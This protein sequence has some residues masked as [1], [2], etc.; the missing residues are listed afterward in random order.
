MDPISFAALVGTAVGLA[1]GVVPFAVGIKNDRFILG[2][3]SFAFCGAVEAAFGLLG[4]IPTAI[5][6][7][8]VLMSKSS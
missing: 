8:L 6:F 1:C 5:I 2:G 4:A 3:T 7:S